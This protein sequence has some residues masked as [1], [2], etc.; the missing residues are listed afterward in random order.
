MSR[1]LHDDSARDVRGEAVRDQ[2]TA[3]RIL[4][5]LDPEAAAYA[6]ASH[7]CPFEDSDIVCPAGC[8]DDANIH[9]FV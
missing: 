8:D 4:A 6:H 3:A 2:L 1:P 7:G 9:L 5:Q